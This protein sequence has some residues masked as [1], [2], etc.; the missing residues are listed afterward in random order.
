MLF[1]QIQ[2]LEDFK[3]LAKEQEVNTKVGVYI[4]NEIMRILPLSGDESI[5]VSQILCKNQ[6]NFF[7]SL[8]LLMG[9]QVMEL[10]FT[11]KKLRHIIK[12][13][14]ARQEAF[15]TKVIDAQEMKLNKIM[16]DLDELIMKKQMKED[17]VFLFDFFQKQLATVLK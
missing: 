8:Y 2:C 9:Q 5:K 13:I 15:A 6:F 11:S 4:V 10:S 14:L 12:S 3:Q 16:D 7:E 17:S 1:S